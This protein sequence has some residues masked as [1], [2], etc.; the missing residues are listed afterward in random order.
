MPVM[1]ARAMVPRLVRVR[2]PSKRSR[3]P[4]APVE[5]F[6]TTYRDGRPRDRV[7]QAAITDEPVD[8]I[9][10]HVVPGTGLSTLVDS[11]SERH[12]LAG[13]EHEDM[14]VPAR[15]LDSVLEESG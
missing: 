7:V 9:T 13:F 8:T 4:R 10:L 5:A 3:G 15:S 1:S 2:G 14:V 6:A 12:D 11:V